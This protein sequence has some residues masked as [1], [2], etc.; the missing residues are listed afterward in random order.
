MNGVQQDGDCQAHQRRANPDQPIIAHSGQGN[1]KSGDGREQ[2]VIQTKQ[3]PA[4]D[5]QSVPACL[6]TCTEL[7]GVIKDVFHH[8]KAHADHGAIDDSVQWA[9]EFVMLD[10]QDQKQD[11]SLGEFLHD[12]SNHT[13]RGQ[14]GRRLRQHKEERQ[15][16]KHIEQ[17]G[18]YRGR[19]CSP[20][21]RGRK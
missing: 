2:G 8:R 21:E 15:A 4:N 14:F 9:V 19:N 3:D 13:A 5:D 6:P 20:N 11:E 1:S 7:C 12:R 17:K 16:E 18:Q 10:K